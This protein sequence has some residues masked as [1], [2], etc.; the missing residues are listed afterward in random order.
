MTPE[1]SLKPLVHWMTEQ[2]R[3]KGLM[4]NP[5]KII[6]LFNILAQ[7]VETTMEIRE[8]LGG[9][10][11]A[12]SIDREHLITVQLSDR[13]GLYGSVP[14]PGGFLYD[15]PRALFAGASVLLPVSIPETPVTWKQI[16]A[17]VDILLRDREIY[18]AK[19]RVV[20]LNASG[21]TGLAAR[22][23][24]ELT[25][26]GFSVDKT[27][28]APLPTKAKL[29]QSFV[30]APADAAPSASFFSSLL[31]IPTAA[32]PTWLTAEEQA[33]TVT[34]VLGKDYVYTPIQDLLPGS[35]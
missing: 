2:A 7:N 5:G 14:E 31:H 29:E 33:S 15:P 4:G 27:G 12:E 18:L 1:K 25:R 22:L 26:Y 3:S 19:P 35:P 28:N 9:A 20:I 6:S 17:F 11:M 16:D 10:K 30:A 13:N 32:A 8:I 23:A 24:Y 21:K 34:I